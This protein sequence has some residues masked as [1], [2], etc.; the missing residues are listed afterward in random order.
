MDNDEES[1][2]S[3]YLRRSE[4]APDESAYLEDKLGKI[5]SIDKTKVEHDPPTG[6]EIVAARK[7]YKT[8]LTELFSLHSAFMIL[9]LVF[10]KYAFHGN[11]KC[12]FAL[13][14]YTESEE[15]KTAIKEQGKFDGI[16]EL[17]YKIN[18]DNS[19][20]H[21]TVWN[22]VDGSYYS[23]ANTWYKSIIDV[24][25][26]YSFDD[27]NGSKADVIWDV[28]F[29]SY[30][31]KLKKDQELELTGDNINVVSIRLAVLEIQCFKD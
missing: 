28:T 20:N 23:T 22:L 11:N 14:N 7:K 26:E 21:K 18:I 4:Y 19:K 2:V 13:I 9:N 29:S 8:A 3:T 5:N 31:F 25:H 1:L 24:I 10:C 27:E 6:N 17:P 15:L 12:K 30:N 16:I